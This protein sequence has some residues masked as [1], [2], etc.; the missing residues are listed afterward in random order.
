MHLDQANSALSPASC[1]AVVL[2]RGSPSSTSSSSAVRFPPAPPSDET[3]RILSGASTLSELPTIPSSRV[4]TRPARASYT[5]SRMVSGGKR[6]YIITTSLITSGDE[7]KR[8]NGDGGS[9]RDLRGMAVCY[10]SPARMPH[11]SDRTRR[12]HSV[13]P[14]ALSNCPGSGPFGIFHRVQAR[15]VP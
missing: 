7:L 5:H 4:T 15:P 2:Q 3:T 12:C 6:T 10:Q 9:A 1:Q 8:R 11:W 14:V 13:L